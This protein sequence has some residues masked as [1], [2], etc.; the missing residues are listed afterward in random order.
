MPA[1]CLLE[2]EGSACLNR[3]LQP[4][5]SARRQECQDSSVP[6]VS[7][8]GPRICRAQ[9]KIKMGDPSFTNDQE[10]HDEDSRTLNQVWGGPRTSHTPTGPPSCLRGSKDGR[11]PSS[12]AREK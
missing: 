9:G 1:V 8:T 5:G 3:S 4:A 7:R 6:P 10:V 11:L 12:A 2:V